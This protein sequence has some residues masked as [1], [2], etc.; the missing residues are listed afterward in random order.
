M[1]VNGCRLEK[2]REWKPIEFYYAAAGEVKQ[3]GKEEGTNNRAYSEERLV[4]YRTGATRTNVKL[5]VCSRN[6]ACQTLTESPQLSN[7]SDI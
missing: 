2:M 4:K 5:V 7:R 1:I 6:I 3:R